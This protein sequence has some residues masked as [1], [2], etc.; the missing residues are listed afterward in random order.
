MSNGKKEIPEEELQIRQQEDELFAEMEKPP[1]KLES[2]IDIVS[3]EYITDEM[4]KKR[5]ASKATQ[6]EKRQRNSSDKKLK[7]KRGRRPGRKKK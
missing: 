3:E 6:R 7:P 5:E 2:F 1:T 4:Q